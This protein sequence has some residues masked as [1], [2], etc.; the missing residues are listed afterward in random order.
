MAYVTS[1]ERI[2]RKMSTREGE[3]KKAREVANEGR[4]MVLP[5]ISDNIYVVGESPFSICNRGE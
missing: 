4:S 3:L 2:G 5:E 1:A